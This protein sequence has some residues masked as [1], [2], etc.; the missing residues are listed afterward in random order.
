MG[1]T[2]ATPKCLRL[3][4]YNV[5]WG[6]LKLPSDIKKDSCGHPIPDTDKAQ[7]Q[8]LTLVAKNIGLMS[9]DICFLQ[10]MGSIEAVEFVRDKLKD[11][12]GVTYKAY[13]SSD[14]TGY[15]AVGL[16]VASS[17][18]YTVESIPDFPLKRAIAVII[19]GVCIV[20]VHLKSLYDHDYTKDTKEQIEQ[21]EC[22]QKWLNGRDAVICGDFNNVPSSKTITTMKDYGFTD[23]LS[24][25]KYVPNITR[26]TFTEFYG[27][28]AEGSQIDYVFASKNLLQGHVSSHIVNIQ[29]ETA[30]NRQSSEYRSENSDHLPLVSIFKI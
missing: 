13:Y 16:L 18:N 28:E 24:T 25:D 17:E 7:E 11:I 15:Q 29:R 6:F 3:M 5:E 14:D 10:E 26:D 20:G 9:P 8:H 22:V 1:N 12:F 30:K 23:M 2:H 27:S 19:G 4:T 21:L